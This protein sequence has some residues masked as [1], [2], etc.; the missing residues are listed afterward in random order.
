MAKIVDENR[1]ILIAALKPPDVLDTLRAASISIELICVRPVD[2]SSGQ[3]LRGLRV[4][5][6][7]KGRRQRA[8]PS[9]CCKHLPRAVALLH[10][11][12]IRLWLSSLKSA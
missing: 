5:H 8:S 11:L 9:P 3:Q 6:K 1:G 12:Q 4:R 7:P 2:M 10:Q